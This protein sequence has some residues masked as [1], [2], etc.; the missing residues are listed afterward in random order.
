MR[1]TFFILMF[2][3]LSSLFSQKHTISGY[4]SDSQSGEKLIGVNIYDAKTFKGTTSNNFGFFSLT[5]DTK[6]VSFTVS[7]VGYAT[8]QKEMILS[9]D[10]SLS[11]EL[12]PALSLSEVTIVGNVAEAGVRSSQMGLIDVPVKVIQNLPAFLGEVDIIKSIQLLPGVQSGS[13]GMSGLYVRGGG[14]DQNL[15]L[16]DGVPVYN[17]NHLFGFFSVFNIDAVQNVKLVKGGFP[18]RY[19]GR[20]SSVLDI[21]MKEGNNRKFKAVGNIGLI[22][23]K[24]S[25]EGPIGENASYIISGR[26]TYL[27]VLIFPFVKLVQ[28]TEDMD[29][30]RL[31]YFF[32][33]FNAKINY[34]ISDKSRIY[35]SSYFG[36]DKFY[37]RMKDSYTNT[38]YDQATNQQYSQ[39]VEENMKSELWWGNITTAVRWN[40]VINN[41][42]FSNTT[43]T[44][45]RYKMLIGSEFSNGVSNEFSSNYTSGI[46]DWA[47]KVD[48]DYYP[49]PNHS[50]K[51]GIS[52]IYHTFNP[53]VSVVKVDF[54]GESRIENTE[55]GDKLFAHEMT[56]YI[57]DDMDLFWG[58]KLNAGI[59]FSGFETHGE[60]YTSIQ[61]RTSLR[62][63]ASE[64]LS[65]KASY[66]QMQQYISM[67]SNSGIGL[68]TDLW[69]P[70]TDRI[71]P[72]QSDLISVGGIYEINKDLEI[73]IEGFYKTMDN[74]IEYKE[75]ANY[76]ET[77]SDWQ[78]KIAMG[79]GWS[80]GLEF[81]LMKKYGNTTGWIG[82]TWS[83]SER[84]FNR[85]GNE[86][87]FGKVFPYTYDRRHDISIVLT[88]K[89]NDHF[90][91]GA[92]WVYGT[93]NATTLATEKYPS[94]DQNGEV[95]N[96]PYNDYHWGGSPELSYYETRNNYRMPAYHRL[97]I[98]FNW[99]KQ[100]KRGL[101]TW[102][103][104]VYNVYNR[105]NPFFVDWGHNNNG[106]MK[107]YSYSLFPIIPSF[108]WRFEF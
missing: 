58:L 62:Y 97:D 39:T 81:L 52:D 79:E 10:M 26:R 37:M 56:A 34:K 108:S 42:L 66:A 86:I 29:K 14:P 93:G 84:K 87:S 94:I 76:F 65:F 32:H 106:E 20:L 24:L 88:H 75:G 17:V 71:K 8:H 60:F 48:F 54:E 80:Y 57:E 77:N 89:F 40:Y 72:Q 104:S 11:I 21:T 51:F 47:A 31:G 44:Y 18:A 27:D 91:I 101:R 5:L 55:G 83:K 68:P 41:R 43:L 19:G 95:Q 23:S 67:L 3:Q 6:V 46:Q 102:N 100:K 78:D 73:S 103:I 96:D 64:K 25:L 98:G 36:K 7:M 69:L 38:Y 9:S 99:H 2:L 45:S 82:Y 13:E 35:I 92:T 107:L 15:I 12:Q 61:P 28:A 90:D 1:I 33:D 85:E 4:V 70:V 49:N 105:K 63:L 22:S 53:G 16:L 30:L 74:I 59:H 50:I